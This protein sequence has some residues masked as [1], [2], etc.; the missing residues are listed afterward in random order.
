[1]ES[2]HLPFQQFGR[3]IAGTAVGQSKTGHSKI[4]DTSTPRIVVRV[5]DPGHKFITTKKFLNPPKTA[6]IILERLREMGFSGDL[7]D[8]EGNSLC[9]TDPLDG[10]QHYRLTCATGSAAQLLC[11]WT[12]ANPLPICKSLSAARQI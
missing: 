2:N 7:Q 6:L 8:S 9:S 5:E 4:V 1:M 11:A 3:E 12:V 10:S